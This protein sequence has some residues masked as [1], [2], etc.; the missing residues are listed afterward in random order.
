MECP[1]CNTEM[2]E[3]EGLLWCDACGINEQS[4]S[5]REAKE[6]EAEFNRLYQP[7]EDYEDF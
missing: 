5:F 1:L 2:I 6:K 3:E 4:Q 7:G